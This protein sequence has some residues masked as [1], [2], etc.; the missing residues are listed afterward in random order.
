MGHY[1]CTPMVLSD[2]GLAGCSGCGV[3][4][5]GVVDG[6]LGRFSAGGFTYTQGAPI[7]ASEGGGDAL[8]SFEDPSNRVPTRVVAGFAQ[9]SSDDLYELVGDDGKVR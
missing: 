9:T 1:I 4:A 5:Q 3:D 6:L 8:L 7:G 2:D